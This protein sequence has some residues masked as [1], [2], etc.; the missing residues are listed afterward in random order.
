MALELSE[1]CDKF[2]TAMTEGA[3]AAAGTPV[4]ADSNISRWR[5]AMRP[6]LRLKSLSEYAL[7]AVVVIAAV[8]MVSNWDARL[9]SNGLAVPVAKAQERLADEGAMPDL[10]DASGWINSSPLNRKS[11]RGKVVLV[12]FW[13]YSCINSLR[14]MPYVKS[15]AATYKDAGLVVVG[16]HTPEFGF[17]KE[18]AN[19]EEAVREL[20][21]TYPNAMDNNYKVWQAFNNQAWPAFYIVDARGRI[22][23]QHFGEGQ[24]V[25]MEAVIQRLLKETGTAVPLRSEVK[26]P[27]IGV[28]APPNWEEARSPETYVG[29]RQAERFASPGPMAEDMRKNYSVPAQLAL[30]QW[31]LSGAW[32]LGE[33]S[34]V[35][36]VGPGSIVYR[37]HSRDVHMVLGP[38]KD[39]KPIR[40]RVTVDG[41]APRDDRGSDVAADGQGEVREPRLYQL[42]RQRGPVRD[43]TFAIEFLDSG[44]HAFSF[45]FG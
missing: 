1:G 8:A 16:V 18:R 35:L 26:L 38:A 31:G 33:E 6:L 30:N 21:I 25:E 34:A 19:V 24:S 28:E 29:Y 11:L 14:P 43:R 4:K 22:R 12:N 44:I 36:Q 9:L 13:T 10:G 41:G 2:W 15:W 17:E 45:T 32:N 37:F 5:F 39:G 23:Y 40:F 3:A 7:E 20:K 42:V 27:A